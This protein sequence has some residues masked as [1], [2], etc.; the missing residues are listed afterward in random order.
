[1]ARKYIIDILL[2]SIFSFAFSQIAEAKTHF[3]LN[4]L[5]YSANIISLYSSDLELFFLGSQAR[6]RA[7]GAAL[8]RR[9]E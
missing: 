6:A 3:S 1:M 5:R 2:S 8:T 7:Q 9:L 4:I